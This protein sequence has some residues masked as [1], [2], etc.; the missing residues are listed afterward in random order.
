MSTH[1]LLAEARKAGVTLAVDGGSLR[2]SATNAPD[3][4]LIARLREAK[5]ELTELLRG[6]RCRAC[7]ERMAWP[8]PAGVILADGTAECRACTDAEIAR[9]HAAAARALAGVVATSDEGEL[10]TAD[11]P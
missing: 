7:G 1:P 8:G 11:E 2:L 10:L 5:S 3:P 6:D 4:A 9:L